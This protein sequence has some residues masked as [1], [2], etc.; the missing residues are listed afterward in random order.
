M[1]N[2]TY[3]EPI[4]FSTESEEYI[5]EYDG[6]NYEVWKGTGKE[7]TAI[8]K[9]L[10]DYYKPLQNYCCSY[11]RLDNTQGHGLTWDVEHIAPKKEFPQFLFEPRNL[12]LSCRD[13]NTH[14]N[15]KSVLDKEKGDF[16]VNYPIDGEFFSIIHP[17]FDD[18]SKY[19]L[20]IKT[21]GG[22]IYKPIHPK[23]HQTYKQCN[24][25]RFLTYK[26][27]N[28]NNSNIADAVMARLVE[29]RV[30]GR[31]NISREDAECILE[32]ISKNLEIEVN[33]SFKEGE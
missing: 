13:C 18:Y 12:S 10:R 16:S 29:L 14:K 24:L 33:T 32:D 8:R 21:D 3:L 26:A 15:K 1:N 31:I 9:E 4:I 20:L 17:H 6:K 5:K 27:H 11:C 28:V 2:V 25:S 7:I 23:G 30:S 19:I 22:Y